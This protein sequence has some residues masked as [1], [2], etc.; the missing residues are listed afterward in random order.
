VNITYRFN[1]IRPKSLDELLTILAKYQR[2]ALPLAGGTDILILIRE[3]RIRPKVLVDMMALKEQLAYI[4]RSNGY[5]RIGALTT[6]EELCESPVFKD[7]RYAGFAGLCHW[8]ATPYIKSMATIGGNI[9]VGH[10]FSDFIILSLVLDA[11]VRL[12]SIRGSRWVPISKLYLDKRLLAKSPDE[13][14]TE[15]R[16]KE[17]PENS[18]TAFMKF[19]RRREH[20]YGYVVTAIYLR[21]RRTDKVIEDVRIAF[22]RVSKRFPER[23]LMTEEFLKGKVFTDEVIEEAMNRI[24]PQEMKRKS[25]FRA[26]AE[27][28]LHLSKILMKRALYLAK[29]R[30]LGERIERI[31]L[32][33]TEFLKLSKT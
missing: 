29:A 31:K 5:I 18:S 4:R 23:A 3:G 22:D 14:I 16:F 8:F 28:R 21:L 6:F 26:T 12:D 32:P 9:A 11:E 25:D 27:Y 19:D 15:V 13:V 30:I 20:I 10:S 17:L 24:L 1:V 7:V 33:I 2:D